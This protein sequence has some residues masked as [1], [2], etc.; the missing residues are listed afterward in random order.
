MGSME[1]HPTLDPW[2]VHPR[3]GV[4]F[5]R[6]LRVP[7]LLTFR[8]PGPV[9]WHRRCCG[10]VAPGMTPFTVVVD[11]GLRPVQWQI[12]VASMLPVLCGLN[13]LSPGEEHTPAAQQ[14]HRPP[15]LQRSL[16]CDSNGTVTRAYNKPDSMTRTTTRGE[17]SRA[18]RAFVPLHNVGH[19][20]GLP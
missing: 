16:F 18:D 5:T 13:F 17:D 8:D 9:H 12:H 15:A 19:C 20:Q 4:I 11:D 2:R 1:S 6:F 3:L 10:H 7:I 14:L